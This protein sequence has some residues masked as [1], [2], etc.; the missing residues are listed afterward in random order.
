M[1]KTGRLIIVHESMERGGPAGEIAAII[2]DKGFDYLDAPIKRVAGLNVS[3]APGMV[4]SPSVP[5]EQ[6]IIDA[7]KSLG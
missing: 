6:N 7:V 4:D 2:A 3:L 5:K 1:K